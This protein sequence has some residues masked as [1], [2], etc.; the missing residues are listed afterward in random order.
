MII[1]IDG[2]SGAGKG[3]L[4]HALSEHLNLAYLDTGL[5][6]RAVAAKTLEGKDSLKVAQTLTHESLYLD[7]LRSDEVAKVAS[8]VALRP[9]IRQALVDFQRTFISAPPFGTNGVVLDGRDIGTV[10]CPEAD[11]KFF[12]TADLET[13]AQRRHKELLNR[14][15]KSIYKTVLEEMR[16]RDRRDRERPVGALLPAEGAFVIDSSSL[17]LQAV[18][19]YVLS[20]IKSPKVM[21]AS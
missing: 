6:Y 2:P 18:V 19:D 13:R 9:E 14:G 8:Q 16:E 10:I 21:A 20:M 11:Y 3:A 12:L 1:A 4:A 15:M 5:L 17:G 7:N